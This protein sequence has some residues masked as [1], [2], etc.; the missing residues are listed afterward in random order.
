VTKIDQ[1]VLNA[2]LRTDFQ[3]FLHRCFK[4]LNPGTPYH[5]GWHLDAIAYRLEQIRHGKVLRQIINCPPRALKSI[6]VSVAHVAYA[7]GLNPRLKV[8]VISY[9]NELAEKHARD[10]ISIVESDWYQRAFP[11]MRISRIANSEVYTTANGF[12]KIASVNSTLTGLG[13]DLFIVD[14]PLK[15]IDAQSEPMR[16]RVNDWVSSTLISRLDNKATGQIIIVMQRVHQQDLT[17]HLL[18]NSNGWDHLCL[19]AIAEIDENIPIRPD[20]FY[21]RKAGEPLQP[22]REPIDVLNTVRREIGSE[23][24]AAQYQQTPVPAGG[25]LFR[26]HWFRYYDIPP[27]RTWKTKIILSWDTAAKAGVRNDYS[28]CTVWLV[29][30]NTP[31]ERDYYLLDMVRGQ[32]EYPRLRQLAISLAEKWKPYRILVEDAST[33]IALAQELQSLGTYVVRPVPATQDKQ[34]RAYV[35]THKFEAGFVHFPRDTPYMMDVEAELLSFPQG[36]HDDIVDSIMQA[37]GHDLSGYD[38]SM[39]WARYL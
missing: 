38:T 34:G 4:T 17:G 23:Q 13:G 27:E 18:K 30:E 15:A 9:S 25:A 16:N 32:Y 31:V 10:F 1:D 2:A 24:F 6:T 11:K 3:T 36:H 28:V 37:L 19:P 39:G 26:R 21:P 12:R 33:G 20:E 35:Q 7:L 29:I 8:F 14:D 5:H 22:E